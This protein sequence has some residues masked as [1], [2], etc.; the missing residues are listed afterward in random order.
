MELT[1]GLLSRDEYLRAIVRVI[2]FVRLN[3]VSNVLVAYGFDCDCPQEQ[4]YEDVAMPLDRLQPFIAE[5]E[6]AGVYRLG[7]NN[8]HVKD[9]TGRIEFLF[10]HESDI[11]FV[12]E[13]RELIERL[14]AAWM[15]EG[16]S[17]IP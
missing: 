17:P 2:E 8:L 15:A 1:T 16:F 7:Q 12:S 6:A 9:T 4:L 11:H 10:C 5:S 14:K 13:D 3:G